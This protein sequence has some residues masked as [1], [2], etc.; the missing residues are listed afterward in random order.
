MD[1]LCIGYRAEAMQTMGLGLEP[2]ADP[3]R[4]MLAEA[5]W[6]PR[7]S[8]GSLCRRGGG[9]GAQGS[10]HC[11]QGAPWRGGQVPLPGCQR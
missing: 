5:G 4:A 7:G 2:S 1:C 10:H 3:G 8:C 9:R 11:S 6:L